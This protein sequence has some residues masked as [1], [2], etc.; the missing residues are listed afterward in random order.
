VEGVWVEGVWVE[1]VWGAGFSG[2]SESGDNGYKVGIPP[3]SWFHLK[4][5]VFREGWRIFNHE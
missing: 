4:A 1:G 2:L 3:H 5:S